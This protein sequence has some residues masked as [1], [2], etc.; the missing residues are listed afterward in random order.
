VTAYQQAITARVGEGWAATFAVDQ[1]ASW[2]G[3][4]ARAQIRYRRGGPTLLAELA[5][6]LTVDGQVTVTLD[7]DDTAALSPLVGEWDLL[8]RPTGGD[9][10]YIAEGPVNITGRVTVPA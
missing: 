9:P 4:T 6:D 3:W 1:P 7:G 8:V 5:V 10:Q 2:T